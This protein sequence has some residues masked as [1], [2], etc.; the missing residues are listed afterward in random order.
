MLTPAVS[1]VAPASDEDFDMPAA[2]MPLNDALCT[3]AATKKCFILSAANQR[4]PPG[5]SSPKCKVNSR[6]R[7]RIMQHSSLV[8]HVQFPTARALVRSRQEPG[9]AIADGL[10][11]ES[12]CSLRTDAAAV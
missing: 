4:S 8:V 7:P 11:R 12:S 1:T 9:R 10:L 3:N 6:A 5:C 2:R